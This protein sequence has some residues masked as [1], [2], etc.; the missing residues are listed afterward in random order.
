MAQGKIRSLGVSNFDVEDL[1]EAARYLT[2][3]TI[4]CN[5][6]LYHLHERG[7]E[8]ALLPYCRQRSIAVVG[9]T[10]FGKRALPTPDTESGADLVAV[11]QRHGASVA[12]VVL[13]F[14]TRGPGLF[15][16]PKASRSEHVRE[17]AGAGD[18][19]LSEEAVQL[20]D[21]HFPAPKSRTP[22]AW[23]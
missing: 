3:E 18:L 8:R 19:S 9:Y 20:I 14:L 11:A 5:Q 10:P 7:I 2:K 6:V 22:L 13:A 4:A 16:I 15:T 23:S 1:E 21:K 17:N 12:Q